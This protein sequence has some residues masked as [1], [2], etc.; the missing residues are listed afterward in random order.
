LES[1]RELLTRAVEQGGPSDT[2]LV[3]LQRLSRVD[4]PANGDRLGRPVRG[5]TLLGG[6]ARRAQQFSWPATAIAC[7]AIASAILLAS[8]PLASWLAE[9][10][11]ATPPAEAQ[12]AEPLPIVRVAEMDLARARSLAADG[13]VRDA[14]RVLDRIDIADPAR[15]D[16]DRLRAEL[17]R[18]LLSPLADAASVAATD[19]VQQGIVR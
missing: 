12:A 18:Q 5:G 6:S 14:L 10:P 8:M 3:F 16:A 11:L 17:Q 7:A 19:P 1:A 9:L 15:P 2:A 4:V 13:R